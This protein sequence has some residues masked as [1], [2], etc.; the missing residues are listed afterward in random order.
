MKI[1]WE[2]E[3]RRQ[4]YILMKYI[5]LRRRQKLKLFLTACSVLISLQR[6]QKRKRKWRVGQFKWRCGWFQKIYDNERLKSCFR[7]SAETCNFTLNWT[8]EGPWQLW[9]A[10]LKK[11]VKWLS[12]TF[13]VS[14]LIFLKKSTKY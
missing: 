2:R 11:F 6:K 7:T 3:S 5:M 10:L 1:M 13:G 12:V 4:R 9:S 8:A 14:L